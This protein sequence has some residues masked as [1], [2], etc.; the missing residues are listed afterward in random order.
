MKNKY[1]NKEIINKLYESA[2]EYK[3]NLLNENI[4]FLSYCIGQ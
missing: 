1:T 4:I 2:K 3:Q